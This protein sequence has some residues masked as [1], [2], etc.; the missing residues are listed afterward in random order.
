MEIGECRM[1]IGECRMEIGEC[2][3]EIGE[4]RMQKDSLGNRNHQIRILNFHFSF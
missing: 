2:R 3:M 4:C 1:E